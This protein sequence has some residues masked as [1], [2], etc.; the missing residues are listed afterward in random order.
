[1][2]VYVIVRFLHGALSTTILDTDGSLAPSVCPERRNNSTSAAGLA[3]ASF[4]GASR[5]GFY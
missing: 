4:V 2:I 3:R 1:M 5:N